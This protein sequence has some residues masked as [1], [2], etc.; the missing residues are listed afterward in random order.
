M[1]KSEEKFTFY[2][3][4]KEKWQKYTRMV[5]MFIMFACCFSH[6]ET[7]Q[8]LNFKIIIA[9]RWNYSIKLRVYIQAI[10]TL[11]LH[12]FFLPT[13]YFA[14]KSKA[15]LRKRSF[16]FFAFLFFLKF[17]QINHEKKKRIPLI[18]G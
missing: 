4:M 16:V 9:V 8:L 1:P 11:S 7:K 15:C 18:S 6:T 2:S 3:E 13:F 10:I 5:W 14:M 17:F 12:S